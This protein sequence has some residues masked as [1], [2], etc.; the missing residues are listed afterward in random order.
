MTFPDGVEHFEGGEQCARCGSSVTFVTC[1]DCGGEKVTHHDCGEDSCCC[2][3]PE[4][5]VPCR[6]C[7]ERG[8]WWRCLSSPEYCNANPL[9]GREH[10]ESIAGHGSNDDD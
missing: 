8:G 7:E 2:L 4:P 9:P 3:Y 6:T 10:V 5:N 1:W